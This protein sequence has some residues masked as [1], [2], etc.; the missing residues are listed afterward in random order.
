MHLIWRFMQEDFTLTNQLML[1]AAESASEKSQ[2]GPLLVA[3][4][5]YETEM[6]ASGI[7]A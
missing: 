7:G 4:T 2:Y 3:L 5:E 6:K 1:P